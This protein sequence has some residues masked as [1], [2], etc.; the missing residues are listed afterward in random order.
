MR[1]LNDYEH[2]LVGRLVEQGLSPRAIASPASSAQVEDIAP[3]DK[4]WHHIRLRYQDNPWKGG[5][6]TVIADWSARDL[7]GGLI[8][9]LVLSDHEDRPYEIEIQ[10]P[11]LQPIQHLPAVGTWT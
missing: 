11:D 1:P 10:R 7:D 2:R 4:A 5:G 3:E 9:L 8:T 6:Y